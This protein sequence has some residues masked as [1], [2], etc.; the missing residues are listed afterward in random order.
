MLSGIPARHSG[1]RF[2]IRGAALPML[3]RNGHAQHTAAI[4][5]ASCGAGFAIGTA[6]GAL[7]ARTRHPASG[8]PRSSN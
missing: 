7:M 8:A 1:S 3:H 2:A 6:A 4:A 5:F